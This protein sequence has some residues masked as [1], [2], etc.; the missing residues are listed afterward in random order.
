MA[1]VILR[2]QLLLLVLM[3]LLISI[4]AQDPTTRLPEERAAESFRARKEKLTRLHFFFHDV[5][6]GKTPTSVT[7]AQAAMTNSS[8]TQFDVI[9]MAD[10]PLTEGPEPNSTLVGRAQGLYGSADQENL[11]L[12]MALNFAFTRG[13]YNGSSLTVLGRNPALDDFREMP[14]LGGSGY[15]RFARGFAV[16]KTYSLDLS[17][18]DAV[19]EYNVTV[20]HR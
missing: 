5:L 6:S 10:D 17:T 3:I 7:V 8:W 4:K 13:K 9:R 18:G 15:F 14:V 12:F 20:A 11:G 2:S 19:V 16:L 1:Q